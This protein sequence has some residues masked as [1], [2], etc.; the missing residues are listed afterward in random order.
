MTKS[1][2]RDDVIASLN[3]LN[4]QFVLRESAAVPP[5]HIEPRPAVSICRVRHRYFPHL[6]VMY[7]STSD[8]SSMDRVPLFMRT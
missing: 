2:I 7:F 1:A 6:V 3:Q 8:S 4:I 5:K